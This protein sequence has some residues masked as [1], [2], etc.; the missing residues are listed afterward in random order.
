MILFKSSRSEIK[1]LSKVILAKN[2]FLEMFNWHNFFYSTL[3]E[4]K[5]CCQYWTNTLLHILFL[6]RT[7]CTSIHVSP[8]SFWFIG[9]WI[10]VFCQKSFFFFVKNSFFGFIKNLFFCWK[11]NFCYVFMYSPIF[12]IFCFVLVLYLKIL[13]PLNNSV[14]IL[15]MVQT[16]IVLCV[17]TILKYY[18]DYSRDP[19][20]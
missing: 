8:L 10:Q 2:I 9:E 4:H 6:I 3:S 12:E 19:H 7:Q 15:W 1:K 14:D 5:I 17:L 16:V 11:V 18:L 20:P 13:G